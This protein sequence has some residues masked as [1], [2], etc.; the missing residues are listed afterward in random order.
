MGIRCEINE[1][2]SRDG[3]TLL[4]TAGKRVWIMVAAMVKLKAFKELRDSGIQ[5]CFV[6]IMESSEDG[7]EDVLFRCQRRNQVE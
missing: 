6:D 4:L 1:Q 7:K 2:G 3:G 5:L